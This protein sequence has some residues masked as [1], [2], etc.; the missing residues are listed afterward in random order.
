M[1]RKLRSRVAGRRSSDFGEPS[2]ARSGVQARRPPAGGS[3]TPRQ[4]KCRADAARTGRQQRQEPR[5]PR[6]GTPALSALRPPASRGRPP[7]TCP[8]EAARLQ[9]NSRSERRDGARVSV[10]VREGSHKMTS[11][12]R[13]PVR[14]RLLSRRLFHLSSSRV[15]VPL[16]GDRSERVPGHCGGSSACVPEE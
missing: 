15:N 2:R 3:P 16:P 10:G 14:R 13:V 8:A 1:T 5:A 12:G 6:P 4:R 9:G 7:G 11:A